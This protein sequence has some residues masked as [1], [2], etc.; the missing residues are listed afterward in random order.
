MEKI[1]ESAYQSAIA[2]KDNYSFVSDTGIASK[3]MSVCKCETNKAPIRYL[4]AALLAKT[5]DN[6]IDTR[7][8]YP[9]L[10]N[11]SFAGRT[12]DE[13]VVQ[14]FIHKYALPCNDT[15][16]FL[17]PAFRT[18][19]TAL[20]KN[21]FEKCRPV[22]VY[23]EMMDILDY[24]EV[25]A[26]ESK[27][28]LI[29]LIKDLIDIKRQTDETLSLMVSKLALDKKQDLS[30]EEITTLLIQHLQCK[31]SSRLPVLMFAAAYQS[32][33][34]LIHEEM[35]PLLA[36]NAADK[37]TGAIGDIEIQLLNDNKTV[38]C[39]EMKKKQVTTDDIFVCVEKIGKL[40]IKPDNYIIIT[41]EAITKEVKDL[42][43]TF[44]DKIGV[45][46]AV[47]D[48]IGFINHFLHFFH[49]Y[50]LSFLNNYQTLVL[51]EPTS[52]V[53]QPLKEAFLS[54]RKVAECE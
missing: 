39:Y 28:I 51:Q 36:H 10:G 22:Y 41:T 4:M 20:T 49:R 30:S 14:P 11:N 37:Q 45:E 53:S 44:Y 26:L 50:R 48:C 27:N 9:K 8:P 33:R 12:I 1:L 18:I 29:Q 21:I 31:G 32:V 7:Q 5:T 19:E 42:A 40:S 25:H 34:P 16:A 47:L 17:T 23:N 52:S 2:A 46:I 43:Y 35:K 24:V 15:T 3:I 13:S 6:S 38:T 54:L